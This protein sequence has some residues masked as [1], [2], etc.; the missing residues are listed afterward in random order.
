MSLFITP[1]RW[2]SALALALVLVAVPARAAPPDDTLLALRARDALRSDIGLRERNLI[3]SVF[4]GEA[5]LTGEVQSADEIARAVALVRKVAGITDV[6]SRLVV[7]RPKR[8][9]FVLPPDEPPSRNETA[10]P[11]P[12]TGQVR[13]LAPNDRDTPLP[14]PPIEPVRPVEPSRPARAVVVVALHAPVPADDEPARLGGEEDLS[15]ALRRLRHADPRLRLVQAEQAGGV[16]WV[17]GPAESADVV[18]AM[19]HG[20]RESRLPGVQRVVVRLTR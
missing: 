12:V 20:L 19:A 11:D 16:L 2:V 3:V 4:R 9:A 15:G 7:V 17:R 1:T 6:Q 8:P 18:W 13:D 14:P 5:I 10:S